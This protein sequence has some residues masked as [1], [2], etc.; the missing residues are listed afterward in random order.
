MSESVFQFVMFIEQKVSK[1]S[2][3]IYGLFLYSLFDI[4]VVC[5][6][7]RVPKILFCL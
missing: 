5:A 4:C 7:Q 6:N 2:F 3:Q 1:E